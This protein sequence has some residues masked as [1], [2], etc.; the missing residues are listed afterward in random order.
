MLIESTPN[1]RRCNFSNVLLLNF[2][3]LHGKRGLNC[4]MSEDSLLSVDDTLEHDAVLTLATLCKTPLMLSPATAAKRTP[5]QDQ[6]EHSRKMCDLRRRGV[7]LFS[8]TSN[9]SRREKPFSAMEEKKGRKTTPASDEGQIV[10]LWFSPTTQQFLCHWWRFD[11][12]SDF[13]DEPRGVG[14]SK[15]TATRLMTSEVVALYA[16]HTVD[17]LCAMRT[18]L[19]TKRN[20]FGQPFRWQD[21]WTLPYHV[22]YSWRASPALEE[23]KRLRRRRHQMLLQYCRALWP[24]DGGK[25]YLVHLVFDSDEESYY[26]QPSVGFCVFDAD[27]D[28]DV[29]TEAY[30]DAKMTLALCQQYP[31]QSGDEGFL[32]IR[33]MV[34]GAEKAEAETDRPVKKQRRAEKESG[35]RSVM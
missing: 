32:Y 16:W 23:N 1:F 27:L 3:A 10:A 25:R 5:T 4:E 12:L 33:Q 24:V 35:A 29:F 2:H 9:V 21:C 14:I 11:S 31:W 22:L 34:G 17:E 20:A 8:D 7:V 26:A 18:A 30:A 13:T 28:Y 6:T 19:K 15:A